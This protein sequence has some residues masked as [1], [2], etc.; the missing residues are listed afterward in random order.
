MELYAWV[1]PAFIP[2]ISPVDHTWVTT[3]DSRE[4]V[5][6]NIG[7]V[8]A[9]NE[10]HWFS[11]GKFHKEGNPRDFPGGLLF[12]TTAPPDK[13]LCLV[14]PDDPKLGRGTI[15]WYGIHGVC[16][17][18]SN[19][20]L[21]PA[22]KSVHF[23]RGYP[24]SSAIY[25]T[26]GRRNRAWNER[27]TACQ[28]APVSMT[29]STRTAS[30]LKT[31]VITLL[32]ADANEPIVVAIEQQREELLK[33]IEDIG[34]AVKSPDETKEQRVESINKRINEFLDGIF[35]TLRGNST[36]YVSLFKIEPG[37]RIDLVDPEL[38]EFPDQE[39]INDWHAGN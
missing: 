32:K 33:A 6:Q 16:H 21:Y 23:A 27:R 13:S 17:Q 2:R 24:L 14:T 18:L 5:Y 29:A 37:V 15:R 22:Q 39:A 3:Y 12:Q 1:T 20:I 25:G 35:V 38:F 19:Q 9:A 8:L 31:R 34:Y 4:T 7:E 26:F 11:W 30:L 10:H 28:I 36:H